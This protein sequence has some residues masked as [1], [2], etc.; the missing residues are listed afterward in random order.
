VTRLFECLQDSLDMKKQRAGVILGY[1]TPI[2]S[3]G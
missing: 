2:V 3:L 1:R